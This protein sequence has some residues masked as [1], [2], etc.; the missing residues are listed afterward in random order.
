MGN[1]A[2]WVLVIVLAGGVALLLLGIAIGRRLEQARAEQRA[3][4]DLA[5]EVDEHQT[6]Y[7][8]L[9]GRSAHWTYRAAHAAAACAPDHCASPAWCFAPACYGNSPATIQDWR[10]AELEH[11]RGQLARQE[12]AAA[13]LEAAPADVTGGQA[14]RPPTSPEDLDLAVRHMI[15]RSQ[16]D[17]AAL[18][19]RNRHTES[20]APDA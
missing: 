8:P 4:E 14:D 15:E 16:L 1:P 2:L 5:A 6:A 11:S 17:I 3:L 9:T 19:A 18:I 13:E 10:A 12:Q 7:M 20:E